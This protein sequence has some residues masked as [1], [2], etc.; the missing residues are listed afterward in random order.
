MCLSAL[1]TAS[2]RRFVSYIFHEV[3]VPLNTAL[4]SFQ[5]LQNNSAFRENTDNELEL[6]ALEGS[7]TMMGKVL[8]DVSRFL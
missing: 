6:H 3:R 7:L 1:R 5:N 8:N 2:K 4:L